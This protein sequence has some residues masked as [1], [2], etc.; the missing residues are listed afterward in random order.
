MTQPSKKIAV[1]GS[2]PMGLACAYELLKNNHQVDIYE[3]D[4]RLGGMSA[5][6]DFD[7]LTI[8]RYYHFICHTDKPLFDLLD[9]LKLS[10]KLRWQDTKMG[11]F[12]DGVLYKWGDPIHLLTFPK[13]DIISKLRYALHVFY[14]KNINNWAKLDQQNAIPWL[15][16]WIGEKAYRMLWDY[17]FELKFYEHKEN[18]SAA[19]IGTRIKRVALSRTNLFT[20]NLGYLEGGTDTLL[21]ALESK[22]KA[23]SGNIYFNS[24]VERILSANNQVQGVL[25]NGEKCFYDGVISTMPLPYVPRLAP[26]LPPKIIAKIE[27]IHNC[28]VVCIILKLR[29]PLTDNFWLNVNDANLEIPGLIEYTNLYPMSESIVY[30][31]FY[32]PKTHTKYNLDDSSFLEETIDYLHRINPAFTQDWII[33]TQVSRYEFAQPICTPDFY[34]QLPPMQTPIKGFVMADTS[35]YYPEDRSISESVKIGKKLAGLMK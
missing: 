18:I 22:I 29:S 31:P 21:Q 27:D 4:D 17:L 10:E 24:G 26:E 3:R 23:N 35:Y 7:G 12:Y 1:I 30:I 20:E 9:E 8:E 13:L 34:K 32:M 11:F 5:C 2:G 19:W 25:V 16:K 28:G 33:A 15:K 14:T 6:F